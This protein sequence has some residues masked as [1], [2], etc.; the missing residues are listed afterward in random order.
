MN[1]IKKTKIEENKAKT[2]EVRIFDFRNSSFPSPS[3][4]FCFSVPFEYSFVTLVIMITA[5]KILAIAKR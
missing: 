1:I 2:I 3:I 4:K 5:R